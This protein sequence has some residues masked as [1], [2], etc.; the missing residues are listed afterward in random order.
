MEPLAT[1]G[2]VVRLLRHR[3]QHGW[4]CPQL[5]TFFC[6][7]DQGVQHVCTSF[8]FCKKAW[9]RVRRTTDRDLESQPHEKVQICNCRKV[10]RTFFLN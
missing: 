5:T 6:S 3:R 7:T 2:A 1:R 8:F 9:M 10:V 4:T